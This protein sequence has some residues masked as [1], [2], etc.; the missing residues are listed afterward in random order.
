MHFVYQILSHV[1]FCS[2]NL[3]HAVMCRLTTRLLSEKCIVRQFRCCANIIYCAYTNLDTSSIAYYTPNIYN[4]PFAP[5][6]Q[7]HIACYST[8]I[9]GDAQEIRTIVVSVAVKL[10]R[11][12]K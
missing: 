10:L 2:T 7:T 11:V 12:I 5:S 4:V 6:L 8:E 1:F 9:Q 3:R